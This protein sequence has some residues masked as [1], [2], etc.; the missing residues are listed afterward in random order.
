MWQFSRGPRVPL[1]WCSLSSGK[2]LM[3]IAKQYPVLF[4]FYFFPPKKLNFLVKSY[5]RVVKTKTKNNNPGTVISDAQHYGTLLAALSTFYWW[6]GDCGAACKFC[7]AGA[8]TV[9]QK[10]GRRHLH[11]FI[12]SDSAAATLICRCEHRKQN[13]T[14]NHFLSHDEENGKK[15]IRNRANSTNTPD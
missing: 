3:L 4:L 13:N 1:F 10:S 11:V 2:V 5:L 15:W 14:S 9:S 12:W 8:T 6:A 7:I